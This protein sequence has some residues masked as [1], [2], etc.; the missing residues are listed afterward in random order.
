MKKLIIRQIRSTIGQSETQRR[1]IKG[2]GLGRINREVVLPDSSAVRGMVTKVQHL[3][4]VRVQ[5]E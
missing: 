2:L 5:A 3:L 1:T 4:D